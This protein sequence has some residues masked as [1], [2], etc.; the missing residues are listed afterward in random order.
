MKIGGRTIGQA[1]PPYVIAEIGVNHDGSA[2]RASDLVVA[3]AE[4]GADAVKFQLFSADRLLSKAAMLARYQEQSG[5]TDPAA[6]LRA[7]ELTSTQLLPAVE[8]AR[9]LEKHV[10]VTVFSIELVPEA[11]LLECDAYKTASPDIIHRPLI[12][13]LMATNQ[14]LILSTGAASLHEVEQ[15]VHWLDE[16]PHILMQCVSAY[17]TPDDSAALAAR[18]ALARLDPWALGYSDHTTAVDTGALAVASGARVLEKHLTHDR[19][20]TGPDHA[21]SLDPA[22]FKEY[23]QLAHRAYRIL[24][25]EEKKV[26][27]IERDVREVSRQS[28]TTAAALPAGHALKPEDLTFKR[29]AGPGTFTPSRLETVIGRRLSRHVDADVPLHEDDLT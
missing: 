25:E 9:D 29:P 11:E 6:M 19:N 23:V 18:H 17:P 4:A 21:A 16:H 1:H 8:R 10:I 26:L 22:Q 13:A 20:A 7:L 14:P 27:D 5:A 2:E 28:L 15:A 12:E 3:A 24:G